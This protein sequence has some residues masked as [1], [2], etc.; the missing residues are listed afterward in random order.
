MDYTSF[1]E[2]WIKNNTPSQAVSLSEQKEEQKQNL[3]EANE[4]GTMGKAKAPVSALSKAPGKPKEL[5]LSTTT[6]LKGAAPQKKKEVE[7]DGPE[8]GGK[9][10]EASTPVIKDGKKVNE[11]K[12]LKMFSKIMESAK[13]EEEVLEEGKLLDKAKQF[14]KTAA[15]LGTAALVGGGAGAVKQAADNYHQ[16]KVN[17]VHQVEK[18]FKGATG[19]DVY[20]GYGGQ[21]ADTFRWNDDGTITATTNDGDVIFNGKIPE[22]YANHLKRIQ[23][24]HGGYENMKNMLNAAIEAGSENFGEKTSYGTNKHKSNN[25]SPIHPSV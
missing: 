17:A 2:A 10:T 9:N 12:G 19:Q 22:E 21:E 5:N 6:A 15:L 25:F 20:K 24:N 18:N 13:K 7:V 14:G 23:Q 8:K 4:Q 1:K 11:S 3:S 16:D